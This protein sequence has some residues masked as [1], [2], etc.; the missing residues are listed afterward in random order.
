MN[1]TFTLVWSAA[2]SAFIVAHEHAKSHGKPSSTSKSAATAAVLLGLL[3]NA[4]FALAGPPVAPPVNALPTGAQVAAGAA[5]ITQSANRMDINQSTQKA[6]LN[7]QSFNIGADAQVNFAQP[8]ASAV[9]LN[10]VLSSDPS[11]IYG[12]LNANGQVFLLNPNGVLFGASARVD[13]GGLVASTMKLDDA[14][15]LAGNYKFSGGSGSVINQGNL[16][17]AQGGYI[18]LLS[19]EVRNEGVISASL[20]TVVL[21]GAEAVTL[22][23]DATGLS[24]AVDKGALQALVENKGLVQADGGQVLLSA[25]SANELASA[26]INNSG[27]I[28]A[29][30]LVSQGGRIVLE[31][32]SITLKTGSTLD[33]SGATGGGTVLVGGDW[34]GSGMLRQATVVSLEK[35]ASINVSATQSGNAGKAVLW[36]DVNK[37]ASVTRVAGEILAKGGALGG[38]GGKVETSG[39][40]LKIGDTASVNTS[41]A[42]GS[43]S[44]EWLLD[45]VDFTIGA[46]GDITGAALTT[47]LGSNKITIT[48]TPSCVITGGAVACTGYAQT[49]AGTTGDIIFNDAV[50]WST[51]TLTLSAYRNIAVN[52]TLGISGDA[53]LTLTTNTGAATGKDIGYLKM[54]QGS[55]SFGGKINW[56]STG[57]LTMNGNAY[58]KVSTQAE[59]AAVTGS[60]KYF[61]ANDI[62]L[63]GTWAPITGYSGIFDGLGHTLSNLSNGAS[64]SADQGLFGTITGATIQNIGITSGTLSGGDNVGAFVGSATSGTNHLRNLFTTSS[65]TISPDGTAQ[66][67]NIGGIIG[68]ST[69]TLNIVGTNNGAKIN[70][71]SGA[72]SNLTKVGGLV[73]HSTGALAIKSSTNSG[74]IIGGKDTAATLGDNV[75]GA[76]WPY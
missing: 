69:T 10:R 32:D 23:V 5:S 26:V 1:K 34:Q 43:K 22:S 58:S 7:W 54:Q 8:N 60:G 75:G 39:H 61:L 51:N 64:T 50:S 2:R 44:G 20:G 24:Y 28:E 33:A 72:T 30:G 49:S 76:C 40:K 47:A 74:T 4:G 13:V 45:P 12:K 9:A 48:T 17:A 38:D 57:V 73:G 16:T 3:G 11:A 18:A 52:C 14:D 56:S 65:V 68:N 35:G 27:T 29:K 31:A 41:G 59:L 42:S 37:D 15:F 53:G 63:T 66:R 6:I 70:G 62:A 46:G 71:P 55:G 19:P 36:S 67:S 21:G 25:R